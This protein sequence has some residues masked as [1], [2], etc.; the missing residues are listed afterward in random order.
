[1]NMNKHLTAI[2]KLHGVD[3]DL[4]VEGDDGHKQT[5][6]EALEAGVMAAMDPIEEAREAASAKG[7]KR[8]KK[9]GS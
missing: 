9:A 2:L 7:G 5:A 6:L 8:G 1:M 3:P 4:V